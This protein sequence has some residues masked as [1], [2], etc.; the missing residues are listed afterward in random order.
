MR[1]D[2]VSCYHQLIPLR[3]LNRLICDFMLRMLVFFIA[4]FFWTAASAE[5]LP[6]AMTADYSGSTDTGPDLGLPLVRN[7]NSADNRLGGTN[8]ADGFNGAEGNDVLVGY[9]AVDSYSFEPGD[10]ADVIV[11]LSP[12][13]NKIRFREVPESSV[14]ISEVPGFNGETDRLISYGDSDAIRIVGWSRLSDETKSA[15]TI[16]YFFRPA[17]DPVPERAGTIVTLLTNPTSLI[18]IILMLAVGIIPLVR[19]FLKRR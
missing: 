17:P 19:E 3:K 9:D 8:L 4:L 10:G 15:W 11:D 7:G 1:V 12:E 14:R 5:T 16:E 2:L 13:G 6:P 18:L